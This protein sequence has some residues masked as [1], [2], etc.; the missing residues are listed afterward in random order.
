MCQAEGMTDDSPDVLAM[1][2]AVKR[3]R[4]SLVD[5]V[6][7]SLA[8][9]AGGTAGLN[10]AHA[11]VFECLDPAGTRL[12][13]LAQRA[14]MT[15]Q[16]MGELVSDLVENGYLERVSDP[17]DGRA[18]LIRATARGRTQSRRAA[19]PLAAIRDR[20]QAELHDVTAAQVVA[21]LEALIAVCEAFAR[22]D[23]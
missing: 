7:R 18:R 3:A 21:G 23:P 13:V 4:S 10:P 8:A 9:E 17:A 6:V 19:A 14:Q 12:T 1:A 2:R 22:P 5:A 15:H 20:W 16:A 11:Q